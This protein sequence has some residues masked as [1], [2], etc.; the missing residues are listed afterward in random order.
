MNA[1]AILFTVMGFLI[2][3]VRPYY[4]KVVMNIAD[5][6]FLA[7]LALVLFTG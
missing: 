4:K 6:L 2:A 5:T 3:V 7:D 1:G